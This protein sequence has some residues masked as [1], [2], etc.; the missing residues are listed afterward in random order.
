MQV[1]LPMGKRVNNYSPGGFAY[2]LAVTVLFVVLSLFPP[3][4]I[5]GIK[6]ARPNLYPEVLEY[7]DSSLPEDILPDLQTLILEPQ[8]LVSDSV[9]LTFGDAD[10]SRTIRIAF[11][12]DSFIEGD[13]FTCNLRE[14]LQSDFGG[15]GVGFVPCQLPFKIYRRTASVSSSL[16]KS[17]GILKVKSA[18]ESLKDKF[19]ATGYL[20]TAG[21]GAVMEWKCGDNF[22]HLRGGDL[23]RVLFLSPSDSRVELLADGEKTLECNV[24][25]SDLLRQ[26]VVHRP[27]EK[28]ELRVLEGELLVYG[29]SFESSSGVIVDNLS[30]RSNNG[31]GIF[32]VSSQ[33]NR[34]FATLL[35][36]DIVVLQ[37]GLNIMLPDKQNYSKY[38]KQLEDMIE[39][40]RA[41]FPESLIVV[42]GVTDRGILREGENEYS[43]I[44]SADALTRHQKAAAENKGVLFWNSW[45][46]MNELGGLP[47]FAERG[48]IATDQT[49]FTYAGG[50]VLAGRMY[51]FMSSLVLEASGH[52]M[53]PLE[54]VDSVPTAPAEI[55]DSRNRL[56]LPDSAE[57]IRN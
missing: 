38:Q 46:E 55:L 57:S 22:S 36:Y 31:G 24:S 30:V 37:Y 56:A 14:H 2:A 12:G 25:G 11:M 50:S 45:S 10:S 18:P 29:A 13:I 17:Y 28:L 27:A 5:F 39:Y 33:L 51:P 23:C 7:D 54:P 16:C 41:I 3:V 52:E 8:P 32:N 19:L 43:S 42:M 40:A 48:W 21:K 53:E 4:E 26:I 49:H 15:A 35:D 20:S 47:V 34:Q 44:R 6:L 9:Q 1:T